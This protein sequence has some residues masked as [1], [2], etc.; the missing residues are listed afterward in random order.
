MRMQ[1]LPGLLALGKDCFPGKFAEQDH[2]PPVPAGQGPSSTDVGLSIFIL[3][4]LLK[5][6]IRTAMLSISSPSLVNTF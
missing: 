2:L 3:K 5:Q 6:Y 1:L 4:T